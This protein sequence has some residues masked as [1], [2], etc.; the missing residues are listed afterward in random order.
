MEPI[1][2][3]DYE[4][5]A[6]EAMEASTWDFFRG[7]SDDEVTLRANCD[8]F[9]HWRLRPRM[10]VGGEP[11]D[12]R[13]TV[14]GT[15]VSMPILVAPTAYHC[16]A[17]PE[18]ECETAR[19]TGAAGTLLAVSTH[20]TRT[21]EEVAQAATGPLWFQLYVY[22]ERNISEALIRRVE[23]AGYRALVLTVD[24]PRLGNRE[25]VRRSGFTLPPGM[26]RANFVQ[27]EKQTVQKQVAGTSGFASH[28]NARFDETLSWEAIDWLRSITSLPILVKGIL[29]ADD[30]RLAV[31]HG[32]DGIIISNHGG[33][34]LDSAV[35]TLD[36]LPEI[37]A[38]VAG[39]SEIYIDGGIRRGTDVL[40]ALALGARAVLV[41]RPVIWGLATHGAA[42]VEHV[43]RIL[44]E[45]LEL[46]M[47]LSG[48]HTLQSID[49]SLV[50]RV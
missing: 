40:K 10:L 11:C 28:A 47:I 31:E 13:T 39:A 22:K 21:L 27:Q 14:L 20:A 1:S 16:L 33:R 3:R 4:K 49:S 36:A 15:P 48:Y 30:A 26:Q 45:E 7:G 23:E 29:R 12:Y 25:Q 35:A 34:Q 8:A 41:G 46:A 32:V 42:G 17:H 5:F 24:A 2:L 44:R 37:V 50:T 19:G 38:A 43:L 6:E 9:Q 18:G